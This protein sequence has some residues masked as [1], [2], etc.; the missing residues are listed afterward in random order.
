MRLFLLLLLAVTPLTAQVSTNVVEGLRSKNVRLVALVNC[1]AIPGPGKQ[2]DSATI[3][4]RDNKIVS[5]GK[6]IPIP[7]AAH[8]RDLQGAWVYAGF[9][10][11]F[12]NVTDIST[13]KGSEKKADKGWREKPGT[14]DQVGSHHWNQAVRPERNGTNTLR[15][16]EETAEKWNSLGYT[17]AGVSSHD[18]IFSGNVAGISLKE[19]SASDIV[20]AD[21]V[22]QRLSFNKGSSQTPYPN[23]LMG[24][25]ALIRQTFMDADWYRQSLSQRN[26]PG[27]EAP[28]VNISLAS[29]SSSV[30]GQSPF[31]V[32]TVDEHDIRRWK[33]IADE[34]GIELIYVG[35]GDEYRR[36][37]SVASLRPT[38]ILPTTLPKVPDVR[39]PVE[40]RQVGLTKL[41]SWYWAP[42]NARLLDSVGCT[43]A[44]T[45]NGVKDKPSYLKTLREFVKR[46]LSK[47]KVI[48]GLTT[49]PASILKIDGHVG[50][51][52]ANKRADLV[53][54]SG[55]LFESSSEVVGIIVG[56]NHR[57]L[58]KDASVDLRGEW[59]LTSN[60]LE[61]GA[62][63]SIKGS[64]NSPS[65][66]TTIDS[67]NLSS[68][69]QRRGSSFSFTIQVDSL[70]TPGIL[71]GTAEADSILA[72]GPLV[73]ADGSIKTFVLQRYTPFEKKDEEKKAAE[74][75]TTRPLPSTMPLG[76]FG[77]DTP[78]KQEDVILKNATV[79]TC[80]P[81]GVQDATD[82]K[83]SGGKVVAVGKG[84]TGGKEYDCTGKHITPGIID[85]HSHIAISRGVNE[86]THAVTTEVRIG[87]VLDPDDVNLYRQLAGGVTASHLLHGSANPMGGQLQ[88]VRLRWGAD[89]EGLKQAD[90][91]PTVKF[92]LGE[93]VKQ[94]NWGDDYTVRYPQTRMGVEEIMRD[95]FQAAKEYRAKR[96]D[97]SIGGAPVRQNLQLDALA[98]VIDGDRFVH[99]HSY[100]QSEILM[101]MRLAEEFGFRLHTFT[102]ILEGYKVAKEM[103]EHGAMASTFSDWWAYK[104]E[105]YQAI[106]ENPAIMHEQGVVVSINSDDAEMARRLNQEAAK[107]IS[108]GGVG[109]EDALKFV[110]LNAAIQ[111]D[112]QDVMG[113]LESGKDADVVVWSGNPL[114]NM[115]RVER[116]FV[117]GRQMFSLELDAKLRK[118][119][120]ELRA[121]LE[122]EAMKAL[123]GGASADRSGS[124]GSRLYHC[125]DNEDEMAGF[126]TRD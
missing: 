9:I 106:P 92:A 3:I 98:E 81:N 63:V 29:L 126:T 24:S 8:I 49:I 120:A 46:G 44:F 68:T 37:A 104:F 31:I 4:I 40:A 28:D 112:A 54:F 76:P 51:I 14:P 86:G 66:T 32:T 101:L 45:T 22:A 43:L 33:R 47:E 25:I 6:G 123:S 64:L 39:D 34:A 99:C 12:V 10:D 17:S 119:D 7:D 56:G 50:T 94:S 100:H 20:I 125:D 26:T 105:V 42:D 61:D 121:F 79:W 87:D 27:A 55:D 77:Y 60:S 95:A 67:I 21:N 114:S 90:A 117:E 19:G 73:L 116:T 83:I 124:N 91:K 48:A 58:K 65:M 69:I 16:T 110:T 111:M 2:I 113:S 80:G 35:S 103:A 107:S 96:K 57:T 23:S 82:V 118:R 38:I 115:S 109:E 30:T 1:T 93:N 52:A 53:I 75:V 62:K 71:R 84:L 41:I 70:G 102:H 85:E 59:T 36:L 13:E 97:A 108:Y 88:F 72:S 18:G 78:P 122:Q 5:V 15:I 89:A 74:S 11:P